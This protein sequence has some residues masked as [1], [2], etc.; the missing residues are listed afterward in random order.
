MSRK[1]IILLHGVGSSG[2]TM[3]PLGAAW[4][5]A[6]PDT[7]VAAPDAPFGFDHGAGWQWFSLVGITP[8]NRPERIVAARESFDRML[9]AILTE[10]GLAGRLDEVVLAGFSQGAIMALDAVAS[11]RWPVAAVVGFSG[12]LATPVPLTPAAQTPVMLI[13]GD[14]DGAIPVAESVSAEAMLLAAGVAAKLHVLR[15]VGHTISPDGAA[16]AGR[17]IAEVLAEAP[18]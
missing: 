16:I 6:M 13:H 3:A 1:L 9:A 12:R 17:F 7:D 4:Q 11:G 5:A 2:A 18:A 8:A 10:H 15:G 14:A